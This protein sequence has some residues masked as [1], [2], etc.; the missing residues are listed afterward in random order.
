MSL[1]SAVF[2]IASGALAWVYVV[3]PI[4][5]RAYGH[6]RPARLAPRLRPP[7]LVTVGLA[8]HNG[9]HEIEGRIADVFRQQVPFDL[10]LVVAC[11]GST[12]DTPEIARR[13]AATDR[14]IKVLVLDRRGQSAAQAAIFEE[15]RGDIVV[16]T[17]VDTRFAAE[18]LAALVAPFAD[19]RVGCTTGVLKWRYDEETQTARHEGLYWR[20]EQAVREWESRAGWLA[21]G[22]GA[23]LA[24]RRSLFRPVAAHASLDQ[25]LPLIACET[26][27][28]VVVVPSATGIDRGLYSVSDQFESRARIATQGIEANLHMALRILPWR[29]PGPSLAI[30]SH[31]LLRWA[32]PY[33]A[34]AA[35][36]AGV[37]AYTETAEVVYLAPPAVATLVAGLALAGYMGVRLQRPLPATGFPLTF[38]TVMLAFT[39]AWI[40]VALGRRVTA[41]GSPPRATTT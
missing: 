11:D 29:Q 10:E 19:P 16:L 14:R 22:T 21:A 30:W 38:A 6:I 9:A 13:L 25:M 28:R 41:W 17:D 39:L 5:A 15:A 37:V 12:D 7:A 31:K 27:Q 33:L 20:Y 8:V 18:C 2:W 1:A 24:V 35:V 36:G 26:G 23:I 34:L 3:Y 32:T 40:R 4:A